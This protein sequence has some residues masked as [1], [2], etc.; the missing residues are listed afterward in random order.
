MENWKISAQQHA[1]AIANAPENAKK[2]YSRITQDFEPWQNMGI[3]QE[4][5]EHAYCTV[6][7]SL[8][9]LMSNYST[10]FT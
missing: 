1:E 3:T 9:Y 8:V 7:F 4:M 10:S 6:R 2:L 5:V